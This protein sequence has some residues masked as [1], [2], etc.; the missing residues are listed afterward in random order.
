MSIGTFFLRE[1][2]GL[3]KRINRVSREYGIEVPMPDG[4][5][6]D[7]DHFAPKA[8]GAHPTILMRVPYGLNGFSTIAELYAERGFHVV[9]QACRGTGDSGGVFEPLVHERDDGLATLE[10][11]KKQPWFDGRI[12]LSGPSY[13]G[14][15]TWAI[16][17]ALPKTAAMATKVTSAEFKSIVFPGGAFHLGLWL[18][19]MQTIEALRDHPLAFVGRILGGGVERRTLRASMKLPLVEADRR[20]VGHKVAFWRRWLVSAF[21][22]E[23]FWEALDHTHRLNAR[24]PPNHFISG[25]Y[26]FMIDQLL[27]DYAALVEAG[28]TPYL[29]VGPWFHVS[30]E[31]NTLSLRETL[32]WMRAHLLGDRTGLREKPVR[33][34]ISG[35]NEWIEADAFPPKPAD[36]QIWHLH[37]DK[38]L[39]RRPVRTSAPDTYRYNPKRPT[40]NLG[41]AIFAFRGAGPV[42]QK[43]LEE[44][45]DVLVFTSDPLFSDLTIVGSPRVTLYARSSLPNTDFFVRLCDVDERGTS[46]NICDGIVRMTSSHAA[47]PDDI[48]KL[49][50]RLHAT[51]HCFL[52]DHR[53]RVQVSSGAHPRYARNTGTDEPI[54]QATRL[55]SADI[56]IFHDPLRPSAIALPLVDV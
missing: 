15:A 25:W 12:G 23:G 55:V 47:V 2:Y 46:T 19:W 9:L 8:K 56:E 22:A 42:D 31:L 36:D 45:P 27:H 50:V 41:G 43:M 20:V 11:I 49:T 26:D 6:L 4:V 28:Q 13:L 34:H 14:Y 54:G 5:V 24:T 48:W 38:V 18:S 44:R 30:A 53:I 37:P 16:S 1:A 32:I 33:I 10:W 21:A 29:T 35:R 40:P 51:A 52:R 7:T 39:S 3:P 17:D